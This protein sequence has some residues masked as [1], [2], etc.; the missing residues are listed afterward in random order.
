M[1]WKPFVCRVSCSKIKPKTCFWT[2]GAP[3]Y[4]SLGSI[5]LEPL[6]FN[7]HVFCFIF[8]HET[9][10]TKGFQSISWAIMWYTKPGFIRALP[11]QS[12]PEPWKWSFGAPIYWSPLIFLTDIVSKL[13]SSFGTDYI[14]NIMGGCFQS[15]FHFLSRWKFQLETSILQF[16]VGVKL[17]VWSKLGPINNAMQCSNSSTAIY[18]SGL[19]ISSSAQPMRF[20]LSSTTRSLK[21]NCM[22]YFQICTACYTVY[23]II[24]DIPSPP[25]VWE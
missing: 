4:W 10:Q 14:A 25:M 17:F 9:R 22:I 6:R 13:L 18:I 21:M 12:F 8:E 19:M 1:D 5:I 24:G 15:C 11:P 20:S 3:L 7:K 2:A 23:M 16:K